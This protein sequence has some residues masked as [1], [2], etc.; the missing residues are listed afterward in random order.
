MI[1]DIATKED[2]ANVHLAVQE[3]KEKTIKWMFIFWLC[4]LVSMFGVFYF[5]LENR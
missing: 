3:A 2:V 5:F 4:Q 1:E